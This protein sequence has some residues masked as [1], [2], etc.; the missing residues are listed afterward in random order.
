V[1]LIAIGLLT[2]PRVTCCVVAYGYLAS[3]LVMPLVSPL[4]R[5]LPARLKEVLS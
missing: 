5:F 2:A 3:P 1:L 4:G